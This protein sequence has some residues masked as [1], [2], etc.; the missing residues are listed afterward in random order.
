MKKL[1]ALLPL[2]LALGLVGAAPAAGDSHTDP[3]SGTAGGIRLT[4]HTHSS[5]TLLFPVDRL[6]YDVAEGESFSY[7]SRPCSG[8]APFNDLGLDFNPD[9]AGIDDDADGTAPVRHHV[10]G[11][12]TEVTGNTGTIE[13]TITSV[14]C[15]TENGVQAE[16][17]SAIV[18]N[19]E[20]RFTRSGD[21]DLMVTGTFTVSPTESTGVFEGLEGH[22]S[23]RGVFTCLAHR[24]DASAPSCAEL[25]EFIDFTGV[26]GDRDKAP[27]EIGPGVRGTYQLG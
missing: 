16:S 11:T 4:I 9:V 20:A 8:T 19:F 23:L 14:L 7:S 15:V 1:R 17:E 10:E 25:G 27:G 3:A 5:G 24:R 12:V 21:N 18:S 2:A 6:P 22:G 13:G 26:R